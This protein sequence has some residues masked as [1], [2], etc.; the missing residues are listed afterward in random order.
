MKKTVV[1]WIIVWVLWFVELFT[2]YTLW[3]V[4]KESEK[5]FDLWTMIYKDYAIQVKLLDCVMN[6]WKNSIVCEPYYKSAWE[7][8]K[9]YQEWLWFAELFNSIK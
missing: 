9:Y 6:E 7:A 1:L 4:S 2:L 8:L 3:S 5:Y